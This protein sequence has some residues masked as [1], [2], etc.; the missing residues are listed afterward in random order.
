MWYDQIWVSEKSATDRSI[1]G[2]CCKE[3][4]SIGNSGKTL[5]KNARSVLTVFDRHRHRHRTLH[6]SVSTQI[7]PLRQK[8]SGIYSTSE[9]RAVNQSQKYSPAIRSLSYRE[10]TQHPALSN[11]WS[12]IETLRIFFLQNLTRAYKSVVPYKRDWLTHGVGV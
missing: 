9:T 7:I 10:L 11:S 1:F 6:R 5:C 3:C 2:A 8:N 4:S 12:V